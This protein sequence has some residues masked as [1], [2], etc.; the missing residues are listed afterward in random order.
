MQLVSISDEVRKEI[1]DMI[2]GIDLGTTNSMIGFYDSIKGFSVLADEHG[3]RALPSVVSYMC[4]RVEVGVDVKGAKV[5]RSVKRA[6]GRSAI[7]VKANNPILRNFVIND[8]DEI[9]K[10]DVD[11]I[12]TPIEVSAEILKVLKNRAEKFGIFT[13]RV[14][15]T[16][17]AYFDDAARNATK[18]AAMIAG[19]NI[20]RMI[21][22]PTAAALVYGLEKG[23][24]GNCYVVYDFGGGTFDLSVIMFHDGV[25]RV[26]ATGGDVFLGG[27]DIDYL[28]LELLNEKVQG[29]EWNIQLAR[30][31]KESLSYVREVDIDGI[32]LTRADLEV[33]CLY[34]IER[35]V[36]ITRNVIADAGKSIDDIHGLLMVGG[37]TKMPLIKSELNKIRPG[38]VIDDAIDPDEAVVMGAALQAFY[39]SSG[40]VNRKLLVDVIPLSLGLETVGGVVER[41]IERNT[42]V[43]IMESREYTTYVDGQTS[44]VFNVCQ[45]ERE[46]VEHNKSIARFE[47]RGIPPLP[48]GKARI[49]VDFSVDVDGLLTVT[50]EEKITGVKQ[51]VV[52]HSSYGLGRD[53]IRSTIEGAILNFDCDLGLRKL[54]EERIRAERIYE[55]IIHSLNSDRELLND[56]EFSKLE[57]LMQ[58]LHVCIAE[59]EDYDTL[60]AVVNKVEESVAQFMKDRVNKRLHVVRDS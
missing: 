55:I 39:L 30:E 10:F 41:I 3:K 48:A 18:E 37:T 27:D 44:M 12:V 31:F 45:G 38:W 59:A 1:P 5:L 36:Q 58:E 24:N 17:P 15:I 35:T 56:I 26:L 16:V 25:F 9:V 13:N 53:F 32:V 23:K 29:R 46:M 42:T 60:N 50:A 49:K 54:A 7:D 6:M 20:V 40:A 14:V 22:E 4:G 11:K 34:L 33:K 43:P 51:S 21:N 52:A 47:L 28:M 8:G 19:L 2:L 57:R